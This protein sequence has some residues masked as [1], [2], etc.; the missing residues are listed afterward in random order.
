[1]PLAPE[2]LPEGAWAVIFISRLKT[3]AP[4]YAETARRMVE[5]VE[6]MP[7]FLGHASW[8]DEEGRGVT[9]SWWRDEESIRRW[10]DHPE[11][12]QA[13]RR[14]DVDWYA[15]WHVQ[16]CRIRKINRKHAR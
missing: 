14:G 8:R 1:M 7:G 5:L 10:R 9:I 2:E 12:V 4:G 3:D 16:I 13:R 11:H 6:T 15:D